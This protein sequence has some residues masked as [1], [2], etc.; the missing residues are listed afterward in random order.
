VQFKDDKVTLTE[1]KRIAKEILKN[2]PRSTL[3]IS[4]HEIS[5]KQLETMFELL[6]Q[7]SKIY[8]SYRKW[9]SAI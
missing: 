9:N 4:K 6:D 3:K 8:Y 7:D 2:F 1:L 5:D